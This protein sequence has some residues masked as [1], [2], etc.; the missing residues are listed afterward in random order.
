MRMNSKFLLLKIIINFFFFKDE[1]NDE[2]ARSA[3]SSMS[4]DVELAENTE[5][6]QSVVMKDTSEQTVIASNSA[7]AD[8]LNQSKT[9]RDVTVGMDSEK[10]LKEA[11]SEM[12]E[13]G[14]SSS[15]KIPSLTKQLQL[16][17]L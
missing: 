5:S 14:G 7:A 10:E 15:H 11:K 6:E 8:E 16:G 4:V 13:K 12:D 2:G 3:P 1:D 17:D 9:E